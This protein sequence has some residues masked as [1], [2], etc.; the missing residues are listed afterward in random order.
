MKQYPFKSPD[1]AHRTLGDEAVVVNFHNSFFY[2]FNTVGTII[3]ELCDGQRTVAQIAAA[4]TAE[5]GVTA[6][7]AARDCQQFIGELVEEGL[8]TWRSSGEAE[9]A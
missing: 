3:W 7:E 9:K 5:Y 2:H 4:L 8:L 1:T 6:A